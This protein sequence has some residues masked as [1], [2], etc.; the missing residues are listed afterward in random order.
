MQ[1]CSSRFAARARLSAICQTTVQPQGKFPGAGT[2]GGTK[3]SIPYAKLGACAGE[4]S[5]RGWLG[6]GLPLLKRRS[7]PRSSLL[8]VLSLIRHALRGARAP[9]PARMRQWRESTRIFSSFSPFRFSSG[10]S[11]YM[12]SGSFGTASEIFV[13]QGVD[14]VIALQLAHGVQHG[15]KHHGKHAEHR[16]ANG[17]PGQ[18][19]GGFKP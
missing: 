2:P 15:D 1:R 7:P 14:R 19:E 17:C 8:K 18:A 12:Q 3:F 16:N 10:Q 11:G 5:R 13:F 6:G 4:R 9:A